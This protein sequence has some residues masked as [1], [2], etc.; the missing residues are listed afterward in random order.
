MSHYK[1]YEETII[2]LKNVALHGG[3]AS[4]VDLHN[5]A[6]GLYNKI[7]EDCEKEGDDFI[8]LKEYWD[9]N[10]QLLLNDDHTLNWDN[11]LLCIVEATLDDVDKETNPF[12]PTIPIE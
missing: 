10:F 5:E 3:V 8:P 4:I 6:V 2:V 11:L 7:C 12:K 1:M 9:D